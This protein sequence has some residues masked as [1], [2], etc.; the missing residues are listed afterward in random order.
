MLGIDDCSKQPQLSV[1]G[2]AEVFHN[3]RVLGTSP[4]SEQTDIMKLLLHHVHVGHLWNPIATLHTLDLLNGHAEQ[5]RNLNL[6]QPRLFPGIL[7]N[8]MGWLVH[9]STSF[10]NEICSLCLQN[11]HFLTLLDVLY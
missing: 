5:R 7:E 1:I 8:L 6:G 10:L 3:F 4:A 2:R 9:V 11:R